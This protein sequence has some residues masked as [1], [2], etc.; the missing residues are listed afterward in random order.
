[1]AIDLVTR[2]L[3]DPGDVII[4]EAPTYP[5][6]VPSFTSYQADVVQIDVD[7]D[8]MRIDLMEETLDRLEREG[9]RPKFIYTVPSF[10]NPPG[11]V[12]GT[13]ASRP[14]RCAPPPCRR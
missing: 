14:R 13:S 12:R 7:A 2:A 3:I 8:C 10:Q 5:G 4:A 1:Q 9:K 11:G 6:A